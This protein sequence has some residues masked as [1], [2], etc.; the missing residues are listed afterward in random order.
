MWPPALEK[1]GVV[2][3][4]GLLPQ[5]LPSQGLPFL[6]IVIFRDET[7]YKGVFFFFFF[8]CEYEQ[9]VQC[10]PTVFLVRIF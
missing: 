9:I 6:S 8:V 3:G 2:A 1:Q 10:F 4:T 5:L 7:V